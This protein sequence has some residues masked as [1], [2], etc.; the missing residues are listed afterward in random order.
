ML[1][2]LNLFPNELIKIAKES[3]YIIKN[4]EDDW[5]KWNVLMGKL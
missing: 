3:H 1:F 5:Y 4:E 2:D